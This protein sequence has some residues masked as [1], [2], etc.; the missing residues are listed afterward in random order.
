MGAALDA[1]R[2]SRVPLR[3]R[4]PASTSNLGPGFDCLG[5]ALSLSLEV[6]LQGPADGPQHAVRRAGEGADRPY[7]PGEDLVLVGFDR[8]CELL[9]SEGV[10]RFDVRSE[11]PLGRGLGSSAAA[12][13]AGLLLARAVAAPET[14]L[15]RLVEE[16][17]R[18]EGHPDN[19]VPAL[20]GGC[21]LSLALPDGSVRSVR[22][23]VSPEVG[24]VSAWPA[25]PF[26]THRAR[27]LL[28]AEVP[29]RDACENPVRL[30]LLLEGLRS[31]DPELLRLGIEDRL[32]VPY[33][34]PAMPD[35][36]RAIAA[37]YAA[38]AWAATLS[39]AGSG[40]IC[41][42]PADEA[43]E[44][45]ANLPDDLTSRAVTVAPAPRVES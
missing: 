13:G 40:V 2:E 28:P 21:T 3:V 20:T 1:S 16:A 14:P 4:V 26:A 36:A 23:E 19:A 27:E 45:A 18:L 10:Y 34:L 32:H 44:L 35:T 9:G 17:A 24:F 29:F 37:A 41:L 31:A 42:C 11:I 7:A 22:P 25:S 12:L 5:L 39:G 33:R 43:E 30:A 38:G 15:E 6:T 8:G